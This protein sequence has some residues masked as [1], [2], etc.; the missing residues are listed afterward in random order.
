[1][2]IIKE[3]EVISKTT[4]K[5]QISFKVIADHIKTLSMAIS[6]GAV[7]S[8]L[9]RGY[10]L[11]RLLRRALKHGRALGIEGTIFNKINFESCAYYGE[12]YPNV[13]ENMTFI[14]QIISIEETKFLETFIDW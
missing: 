12:T 4:Y 8:N 9:G 14:N 6:D 5:G 3:I 11:R 7:L 1:M 2:P 10:V 13:V